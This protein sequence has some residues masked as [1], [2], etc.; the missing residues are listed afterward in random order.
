[1]YNS[2]RLQKPYVV[3]TI[4]L[5]ILQTSKLTA[6]YLTRVTTSEVIIGSGFKL[7]SLEI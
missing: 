4:I 1:M 6:I 2:Q 5:S 3:V 7:Q